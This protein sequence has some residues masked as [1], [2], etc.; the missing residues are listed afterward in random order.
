MRKTVLLAATL[1]AFSSIPAAHAASSASATLDWSLFSYEFLK[2]T[3]SFALESSSAS[4]DGGSF[5]GGRKSSFSDSSASS[6]SFGFTGLSGESV[7][8]RTALGANANA[9]YGPTRDSGGMMLGS[10]SVMGSIT[11]DPGAIL[12]FSVPFAI[13][14]TSDTGDW[15]SASALLSASY[16]QN[17]VFRSWSDHAG[18]PSNP[19]GLDAKDSGVLG[20]II[21]N[22]STSAQTYAFQA[23]AG[24]QAF[25][26]TVAPVPEPE[27]YSMMMAG[28]GLLGFVTRKRK[29][30]AV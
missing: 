1:A 6:A 8:N 15:A 4:V 20:L 16:F 24:V 11:L 17:G 10:S 13:H 2:G 9:Q 23:G 25:T 27:T 30:A 18:T 26:T 12:E 22:S 5:F 7:A 19:S 14:A 3:G 29:K 21:K 28:L